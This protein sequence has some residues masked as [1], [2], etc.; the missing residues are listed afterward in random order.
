MQGRAGDA[1]PGAGRGLKE[2]VNQ[3]SEVTTLAAN[4]VLGFGI[5]G[6]GVI[7]PTHAKALRSLPGGQL[8]AVTD[9]VAERAEKLAKDFDVEV[10][11][12]VEELAA[13]PDIDV[14]CVCVPSGLHV[15]VA[16]EAVAAGKHVVVEKPIDVSLEAANRLI[17]AGHDAGVVVSVISQHRFDPGIRELKDLVDSGALG[18]VVVADTRIKWYRSQAYYDSGDWRGTWALDGGGALMNQGI[19]YV[20]MVRWIVGLPAEVTAITATNC[21]ER[22]EV[23]DS[24][25]ALLRW[26]SGAVGILEAST[27]VFPGMSERLEISGTGGTGVVEG[28][29][30]IIKEQIAEGEVGR[31]GRT[32]RSDQAATETAAADPKAVGA[33]GHVAQLGDVIDAINTGRSPLMTGEEARDSL[34]LA[35]AVYESARRGGTVRLPLMAG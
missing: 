20:D 33:V 25:L 35:L 3:Q 28:G 27:S 18:Q 1:T 26:S 13:R 34:Q 4:G 12:S 29:R 6:C 8:V 19:H 32:I 15:E 31:Y 16:L 30:L 21:H 10:A 14:V 24:A 9:V 11:G 17:K 5:V 22:I 2:R 7:G 23:E